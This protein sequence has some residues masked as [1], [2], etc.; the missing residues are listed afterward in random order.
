MIARSCSGL[1]DG[2]YGGGGV[3]PEGDRLEMQCFSVDKTMADKKAVP[4]EFHG[5]GVSRRETL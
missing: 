5:E 4:V 1:L 2:L 3:A